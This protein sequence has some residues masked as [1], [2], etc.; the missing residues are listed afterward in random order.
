MP[1]SSTKQAE[2]TGS[3]IV[4]SVTA[5]SLT[6]SALLTRDGIAHAII[7]GQAV[8]LLGSSRRTQVW[9][10]AHHINIV[11]FSAANSYLMP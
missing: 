2:S 10:E 1:S 6:T 9:M 8:R 3:Q 11:V 7:G 4:A 5:A